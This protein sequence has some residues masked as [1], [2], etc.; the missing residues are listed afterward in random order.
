MELLR[1]VRRWLISQ[2]RNWLC[3]YKRATTTLS[4]PRSALT[5]ASIVY[6]MITHSIGDSIARRIWN[7]N[8]T[9]SMNLHRIEL[10]I[11]ICEFYRISQQFALRKIHKNALSSPSQAKSINLSNWQRN[12]EWQP[13]LRG[14]WCMWRDKQKKKP[15]AEC[16][17][18]Q[19]S[20]WNRN[21]IS[22]WRCKHTSI[23]CFF[24]LS[25]HFLAK[26]SVQQTHF[27]M[28][29]RRSWKSFENQS[30]EVIGCS[31]MQ[32]ISF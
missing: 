6:A 17:C 30:E 7:N 14:V 5:I 22:R 24:L 3:P 25:A 31:H 16:A 11:F 18:C 4:D 29:R 32:R 19:C 23:L 2:W 10:I 20:K 8:A 13:R 15:N 12:F 21:P 9:D 1:R 26:A 28:N 27:E